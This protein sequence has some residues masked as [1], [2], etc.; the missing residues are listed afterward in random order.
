MSKNQQPKAVTVIDASLPSWRNYFNE[1]YQ[2]RSVATV[3]IR[4]DLIVRFRQ[5]FFGIAWLLF[6][7]L[8]MMIVISLAFGFISRFDSVTEAPYPLVV[9]CG[10]IPWYFVSNAVPDGMNSIVGHLP[11]L[12][13][14][15]FPR[16]IIPLVAI[17]T[18]T[19]EFFVAWLLFALACAWYGFMPSWQLAFFPLFL[20]LNIVLATG[21]AL[22]LSLMNARFRDV[23]NLIPFLISI[24]FFLTPIGYTTAAVPESWR[25]IYMLNPMAGI[26]EGIRWSLLAGTFPL[27]LVEIL[28]SAA[29]ALTIF[30]SGLWYFWRNEST[31]VDIG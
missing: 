18:N 6:K 22:W 24:A 9:L 14:T 27:P 30:S 11:I 21:L 16:M 8:M 20:L 13:K 1:I 17:A 12:H 26:V 29:S 5:T 28:T 2:Y 3:L 15:Y 10:V 4:R 31:I 23:G 19:I 25:S 7:P